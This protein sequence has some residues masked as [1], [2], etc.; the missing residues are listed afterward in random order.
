MSN[1]DNKLKLVY[2]V[3]DLT[4]RCNQKC[5]YCYAEANTNINELSTEQWLELLTNLYNN[6]LRA[7]VLSGGE[8]F[9]HSG[10][11]D[12]LEFCSNFFITEINTNGQY[13]N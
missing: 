10:F 11:L 9:L 3:I 5:K 13:I 1:L 12:I 2:A 8:P 7:V 6:G 4:N